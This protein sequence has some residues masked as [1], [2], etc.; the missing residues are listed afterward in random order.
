MFSSGRFI[1][2][3]REGSKGAVK[4]SKEVI[5]CCWCEGERVGEERD[6]FREGLGGGSGEENTGEALEEERTREDE[7]GKG[8]IVS[9]TMA[10]E[11]AS[12]E[13]G[14]AASK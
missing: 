2:G 14:R 10:T 11:G 12:F 7:A 13:T 8:D 1:C 4:D 9:A 3:G 5:L 6:L